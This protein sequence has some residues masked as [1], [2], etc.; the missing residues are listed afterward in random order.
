MDVNVLGECKDPRGC[1]RAYACV[2]V[3]MCRC[4][5]VR[6]RMCRCARACGCAE[7]CMCT[8]VWVCV[9]GHVDVRARVCVRVRVPKTCSAHETVALLALTRHDALQLTTRCGVALPPRPKKF[10]EPAPAPAA[11]S[12][13]SSS[14][15]NGKAV[16]CVQGYARCIYVDPKRGHDAAAGTK[17]QPLQT[18]AASRSQIKNQLKLKWCNIWIRD[19]FC[20]HHLWCPGVRTKTRL[21]SRFCN[22]EV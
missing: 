8:C 1:A 21:E 4:T 11:P 12:L 6:V 22:K 18:I 7:V 20:S 2:R 5:D 13:P 10:Q 19:V 17:G 16:D 9:C 15:R 14:A 3:S